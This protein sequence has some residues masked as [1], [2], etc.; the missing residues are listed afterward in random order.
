[1]SQNTVLWNYI[2]NGAEVNGIRGLRSSSAGWE[3]LKVWHQT[4]PAWAVLLGGLGLFG[5]APG[6][7]HGV[8]EQHGDGH[9]SDAAR[10]FCDGADYVFS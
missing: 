7:F 2:R 5:D 1:M 6:G 9:G 8:L 10:D 4:L 3:R